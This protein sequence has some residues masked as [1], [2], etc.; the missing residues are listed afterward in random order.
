MGETWSRVWWAA[1][2]VAGV[3]FGCGPG[4]SDAGGPCDGCVEVPPPAWSQTAG[5]AG[6]DRATALY[7]SGDSLL[8]GGQG[9]LLRSVD[10][11]RT[12]AASVGLGGGRVASVIAAGSR[13]FALLE[14]AALFRS[15][16]GGASWSAVEV[17]GTV[18][19][20]AS[21]GSSLF[22]V[23][24]GEAG[25]SVLASDDGGESWSALASLGE[26]VARIFAAGGTLFV[27]DPTAGR[28]YRRDGSSWVEAGS[29]GV[30]QA[31]ALAFHQGALFALS[32]GAGQIFRSADGGA[33]WTETPLPGSGLAFGSSWLAETPAGL[34]AAVGAGSV[35][36]LDDASA[37]WRDARAGLAPGFVAAFH[38]GDA[39]LFAVVEDQL[40]RF[41]GETG[42][43]AEVQGNLIRTRIESLASDGADLAA[44]DAHGRLHLSPD[45]GRTWNRAAPVLPWAPEI[46]SV[47]VLQGGALLA[48]T[49]ADGPFV[50][51]DG[52]WAG[53]GQGWPRYYGTAGEQARE[54]GS[55]VVQGEAIWVAAGY[56]IERLDA[57]GN[58]WALSGAGVYRSG[59]GGNSW[60]QVAEGLPVVGRNLYGG[61][62]ID[63]VETLAVAG[64]RLF[65][66]TATRGLFRWED[67]WLKVGE[68]LPPSSPEGP[69]PVVELV[70]SRERLWALVELGGAT[71]LFV[72]EDAGLSF[73]GAPGTPT[74]G[75]R[76]AVLGMARGRPVVSFRDGQG[77]DLGIWTSADGGA[78]WA[79]FGEG[80]PAAPASA[81]LEADGFLFAATAGAGVWRLPLP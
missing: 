26:G 29:G 55:I 65:A 58:P 46:S 28:L 50:S 19:S 79:P 49:R 16:D 75:A 3:L 36:R 24:R 23:V 39:G 74:A 33:G 78:T 42:R 53:A 30:G 41:D 73:R 59:D 81:L 18:L 15:A 7:A 57:Q 66:S 4:A 9:E 8:L 27:A 13:L 67:R 60:S 40:H 35:L 77:A 17:P 64:G 12:W 63:P 72:S 25:R 71:G 21:V 37:T 5:P 1:A 76:A 51:R 69:D 70:G 34:F 6:S 10:G 22:A 62:V 52:V 20:L 14:P 47:A 44:I 45:A 43:W 32:Q 31:E 48:G 11:G 68:G 38:G 54:V 61:E 56:G 2:L 80:T